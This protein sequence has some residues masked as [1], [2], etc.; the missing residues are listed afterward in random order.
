M[1]GCIHGPNPV[2]PTL[3]FRT[4]V[5]AIYCFNQTHCLEAAWS[6]GLIFT[7]LRTSSLS[8]FDDNALAETSEAR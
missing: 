7:R 4:V 1:N 8:S 6:I 5:S 3:T 2:L